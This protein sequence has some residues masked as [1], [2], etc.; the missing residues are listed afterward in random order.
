MFMLYFIPS[1]VPALQQKLHHKFCDASDV[2]VLVENAF[3]SYLP[4][5]EVSLIKEGFL[6]E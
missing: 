5:G 4:D 6:P 2:R 3:N 1:S